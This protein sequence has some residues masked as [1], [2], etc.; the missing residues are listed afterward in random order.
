[1]GFDPVSYLMGKASGGGGGGGVVLSG[2]ST[3]SASIGNNEDLYIQYE[4]C[5]PPYDHTYKIVGQFRKVDG[6]W[7]TYVNP[8]MPTIGIHVWTKSTGG[9]DASM[10][11]Q[12]GWQ[13]ETQGVF[14]PTKD[15]VSIFYE[16]ARTEVDLYGIATLVYA[17]QWVLKAS[18][19]LTNGSKTF[20]AGSNIRIWQYN[21]N[22]DI[23]VWKPSV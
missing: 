9:T 11:V 2:T 6:S 1:M 21:N 17:N 10:Y 18:V 5:S 19:N 8:S 7:V 12:R 20:S 23:T 15:A 4:I 22:V 16:D 13:D 3:P 14:V